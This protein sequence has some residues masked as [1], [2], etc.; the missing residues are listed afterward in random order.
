MW[1]PVAQ[2][3]NPAV[4]GQGHGD[5]HG[6]SAKDPHPLDC[7]LASVLCL[8]M[9]IHCEEVGLGPIQVCMRTTVPMNMSSH[10]VSEPACFG[11]APAPGERVHNVGI[12]LN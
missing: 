4:G 6:L 1:V 2:H 7:G 3:C 11:A 10:G 9:L 12:F 8:M 5:A